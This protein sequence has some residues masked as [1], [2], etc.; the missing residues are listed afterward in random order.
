MP[1]LEE[2]Y[3]LKLKT[4][5]HT[6]FIETGTLHGKTILS[7]EKHFNKL[8]TI[9]VYEKL[10]TN[11]KNKYKGDKIEFILGD[12]S[13]VF[14]DLLPTISQ[15]TIFFL[16]GHYSSGVTSFGEK[17]CPLYEELEMI[18]TKFEYNGIIIIDDARLF[19]KLDGGVCDWTEISTDKLLDKLK[20][21]I[22]KVETYPSKLAKNDRLVIHIK[23]MEKQSQ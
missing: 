18:N 9:E 2:E 22:V 8:Y 14:Q 11:C 21:R 6:V 3:I 13:I 19:G 16:D 4:P 10:Y 1:A 5:N 12:S 17:H 20:D 23:A 15:D 7:M